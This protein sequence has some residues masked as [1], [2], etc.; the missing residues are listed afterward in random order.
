MKK[1]MFMLMAFVLILTACSSHSEPVIDEPE[2]N[3]PGSSGPSEPVVSE[4]EEDVLEIDYE[5]YESLRNYTASGER[6]FDLPSMQDDLICFTFEV[7][8][9]T[10]IDKSE[11]PYI[12]ENPEWC[13]NGT[14]WIQTH[15]EYFVQYLC[16]GEEAAELAKAI[17]LLNLHYSTFDISTKPFDNISDAH[18]KE[19]LWAAVLQTPCKTFS[20][21]ENHAF[22]F[23]LNLLSELSDY[24]YVPCDIYSV[25]DVEKTFRYL[26]GEEANFVP[27]DISCYWLRY[28]E[29][30][31][32]FVQFADGIMIFPGY[33][34]I[35]NYSEKDGVYTVET[36]MAQCNHNDELEFS[37]LL[38]DGTY[39]DI[40]LNKENAL[41]VSEIFKPFVYTFEKAEDG[42][43][44]LTGFS[45]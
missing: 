11:L 43:F 8:D 34:Q 23:T 42:H 45:F 35:V 17:A 21:N 13:L 7:P 1:I 27:Q 38:T 2:I 37:V 14:D 28:F 3:M 10:G 16:E 30:L 9:L 20:K 39:A 36:I 26:F 22:N 41:L 29:E 5:S 4:P 32:V 31:G 44:V 19:L 25:S 24:G 6:E 40:P 18:E 12:F 33:P 15:D